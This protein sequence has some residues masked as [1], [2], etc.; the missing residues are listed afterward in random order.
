MEK[1]INKSNLDKISWDN[2]V[3]T[4]HYNNGLV[5][6]YLN[7]PEGI[8]VGMSYAP[9]AGSYMRLYICGKYKYQVVQNS[10]MKEQN[11]KLLHYKDTTVGLFATD[12][13]DLIPNEIKHL[14]C[15]LTFDEH[16]P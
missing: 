8:A 6:N 3:L 12:R 16:Q 5:V 9:S 13:P 15:E 4:V 7:V 10:D 1:Y 14:F 11:K 2:E